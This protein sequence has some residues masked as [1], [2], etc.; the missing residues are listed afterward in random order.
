LFG[1]NV[2][3][4]TSTCAMQNTNA[5]WWVSGCA[6]GCLGSVTVS[7][8]VNFYSGGNRTLY[9]NFNNGDNSTG[10]VSAGSVNVTVPPVT[11]PTVSGPANVGAASVW[12][13]TAGNSVCNLGGPVQYLFNRG[14]NTNSGWLAEGTL[15]ASHQWAWPGTDNVIVAG[16]L[17][18]LHRFGFLALKPAFGYDLAPGGG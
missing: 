8:P 17:R 13:Y 2:I 14:D 15:S 5:S 7:I 10:W 12:T 6:Q 16:T 1:G 11:T 4:N 3:S 9:L 18:E